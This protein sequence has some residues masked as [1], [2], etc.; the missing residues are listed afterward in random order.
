MMQT[1]QRGNPPRRKRIFVPSGLIFLGIVIAMIWIIDSVWRKFLYQPPDPEVWLEVNGTFADH[2]LEPVDPEN[3]DPNHIL[4]FN[5]TPGTSAVGGLM[6][7]MAID[8]KRELYYYSQDE[9]IA[10]KKRMIKIDKDYE[11]L[12]NQFSKTLEKIQ[13]QER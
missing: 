3:D 9:N 11:S 10:D 1:K 6:T 12:K 13:D 8:P 7:L 5:L 4:C 2:P